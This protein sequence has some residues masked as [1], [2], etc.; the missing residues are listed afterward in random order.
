MGAPSFLP[1]LAGVFTVA[2]HAART[3]IVSL[4]NAEHLTVPAWR[5]ITDSLAELRGGIQHAIILHPIIL[6]HSAIKNA[7]YQ[8]EL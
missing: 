3:M 6:P 2:L 7:P 1:C 5:K 4:S 8:A